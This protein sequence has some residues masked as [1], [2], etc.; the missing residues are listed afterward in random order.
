[1]ENKKMKPYYGFLADFN[2]AYEMPTP[3]ES[4]RHLM[5]RIG[6][7]LETLDRLKE[8]NNKKDFK[9]K[10]GNIYLK[11]KGILNV[12]FGLSAAYPEGYCFILEGCYIEGLKLIEPPIIRG[13]D[14]TKVKCSI[15]NITDRTIKFSIN[16]F[17]AYGSFY[18]WKNNCPKKVSKNYSVYSGF[19]MT[20]FL[21]KVEE[22]NGRKEEDESSVQG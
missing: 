14:N 16:N 21:N 7:K 13:K 3:T 6:E 1:M 20:D 18:K 8:L 19:T 9:I 11:P 15:I 22:L 12:D 5:F 17:L 2:D 4:K 10:D